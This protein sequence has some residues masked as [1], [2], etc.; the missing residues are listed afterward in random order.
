MSAV[1]A[2][3]PAFNEEDTLAS[4]I[5]AVKSCPDID[6]VIVVNDGS[7]DTTSRVAHTQEGITVLDLPRNCGKGL[8]LLTGL[9]ST[10]APLIVLMDADLRGLTSLHI[11]SVLAPVRQGACMMS[12]GI[13]DRGSLWMRFMKW[14]SGRGAASSLLLLSG[15]RALSRTLFENIPRSQL[16]RYGFEVALNEYCRKAHLPVAVVDLEG[17]HH[18]IKEKKLGVWYGFIARI[19]MIGNVVGTLVKI[20]RAGA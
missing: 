5:Q 10:S 3:I 20:R 16:Q 2:L 8:A 18:V 1:A 14:V 19:K 7:T 13:I 6:E 4:V 12:V 9:R 15:Q 17:V 11:S